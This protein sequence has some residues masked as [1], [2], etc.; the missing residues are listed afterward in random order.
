MALVQRLTG[1]SGSRGDIEETQTDQPQNA[2]DP[3]SPPPQPPDQEIDE[4]TSKIVVNN[5]ENESSSVTTGCCSN[6]VGD[7]QVNSCLISQQNPCDLLPVVRSTSADFL[8]PSQPFC[9]Y[10]DSIRF[11]GASMRTPVPTSSSN[12]FHEHTC[13]GYSGVEGVGLGAVIRDATGFLLGAMAKKVPG[14]F[15]SFFGEC[16]ALHDGLQF[17]MDSD[18][19]V[20]IVGCDATQVA[21]CVDDSEVLA[22]EGLIIEDISVALNVFGGTCYAFF[23][24]C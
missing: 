4:R 7:G 6:N 14:F 23:A 18:L 12:E 10:N 3:S 24:S 1:L 2:G 15:S 19:R 16:L 17:A 11:A 20:Q 13:F 9:N 21:S 22:P 8:C 5:D